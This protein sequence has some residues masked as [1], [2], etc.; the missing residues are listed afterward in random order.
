M[1]KFRWTK[2]DGANWTV[3]EASLPYNISGVTD[4]DTVIVEPIGDV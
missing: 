4:S 2:D 3:V 1:A